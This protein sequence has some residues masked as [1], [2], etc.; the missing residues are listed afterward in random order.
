MLK[1]YPHKVEESISTI[2]ISGSYQDEDN[3]WTSFA[4]YED[5]HA[6]G[7]KLT[8][9]GHVS[10]EIPAGD[11]I[12]LYIY[13]L[14]TE[15][16]LNG[17]VLYSSDKSNLT[18]WENFECPGIGLDDEITI[19]MNLLTN[20]PYE[21]SYQILLEHLSN[22]SEMELLH[23]QVKQNLVKIIFCILTF[24]MGI[25]TLFI[26][27]SLLFLQVPQTQGYLSCGLLMIVGSICSFIDYEYITLIFNN[28]FMINV[29]DFVTQVLIPIILL[30]YLKLYI[31]TYKYI[32]ITNCMIVIV[33][34]SL[35]V[36]FIRKVVKAVDETEC[37]GILATEVIIM[38][39]IEGYFLLK[40]FKAN[41][42]TRVKRVLV[43]ALLLTGCASLEIIHYI[44]TNIFWIYV[45]Q[46]GLITFAIIQY[47]VLIS[48]SKEMIQDAQQKRK[49]EMEV[50]KSQ[51][52]VM[53]SQIQPHFLYNTISGIQVLCTHEPK[54]AGEALN[55]F[56][57]FLRANMD[58]LS[59]TD[60]IPFKQE[61]EHV[62]DFVYLQ[63][64]RLEERL[65]VNYNIQVEDFT[66]PALT[67]QPLVENAIHHGISGKAEGGTV[68]ISTVRGDHQIQIEIVDD[69][70]GFDVAAYELE[71]KRQKKGTL[72]M[73]HVGIENIRTRIELQFQGVVTIQS[74]PGQGT[75]VKIIIP[76]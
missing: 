10:E 57:R 58:S 19:T 74:E 48:Y 56:G 2:L 68:T 47:L 46:V 51:I 53:M 38:F 62:K 59:T 67:M 63:Q 42:E 21:G 28:P 76:E 44:I 52:A 18:R 54:K 20:R 26:S 27:A 34:S 35:V 4:K 73:S 40:D 43:S 22:G 1:K 14:E 36:Y 15:V 41:P 65:K 70:V 50:V 69:G 72:P 31:S 5:I 16:K 24:L 6:A 29:I 75:K 25:V 12:M 61:M 64:M 45:F 17:N 3:D 9:K 39:L 37:I 71:I 32:K 11:K 60:R 13:R 33:S 30:I 49:L 8:I 23:K 66:I 7:K 55:K